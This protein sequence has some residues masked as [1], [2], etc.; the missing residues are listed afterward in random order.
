MIEV[1]FEAAL[2]MNEILLEKRQ[3]RAFLAEGTA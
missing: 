2:R 3:E 1:A